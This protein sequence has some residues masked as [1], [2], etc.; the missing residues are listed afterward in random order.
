MACKNSSCSVGPAGSA[1][2]GGTYECA[3]SGLLPQATW[4]CRQK[5]RQESQPRQFPTQAE[6]ASQRCFVGLA[7]S[8]GLA[9]GMKGV[10][11]D[12][13]PPTGQQTDKR[14][15]ICQKNP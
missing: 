5:Q 9:G 8:M 4:H 6:Q 7:G 10:P 13:Q 1:S 2:G 14:K 3:Q 11:F 15:A 12:A